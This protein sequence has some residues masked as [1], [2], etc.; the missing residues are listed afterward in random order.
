MEYETFEDVADGVPRFIQTYNTRRLHSAQGYLSPNQFGDR[1]AR[2][3]FK[4]AA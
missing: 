3:P 2:T 4:T 1:N